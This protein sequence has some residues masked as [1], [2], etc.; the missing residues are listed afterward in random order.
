MAA[1]KSATPPDKEPAYKD[2][3]QINVPIGPVRMELAKLQ[4]NGSDVVP[5]SAVLEIIHSILHEEKS[6]G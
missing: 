6:D 3:D 1:K 5:L 4:T 2:F